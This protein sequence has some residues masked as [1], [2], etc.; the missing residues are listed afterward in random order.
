MERYIP[1]AVKPKRS[2]KGDEA[3]VNWRA[4]RKKLTREDLECEAGINYVRL[5]YPRVRIVHV[6]NEGKRTPLERL[7][8]A[9]LGSA[10]GFVDYMFFFEGRV[11]YLEWKTTKGAMTKEQ[12][13]WQAFLASEGHSV[14]NIKGFD[15]FKEVFDEWMNHFMV[16]V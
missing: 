6:P 5:Q 1:K 13:E 8:L 16:K 4:L 2:K 12:K 10:R 3:P 7:R 14:F 9:V 11:L 15:H